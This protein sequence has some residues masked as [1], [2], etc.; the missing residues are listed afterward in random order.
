M[1]RNVSKILAIVMALALAMSFAA[2]SAFAIE[3]TT[4]N[5]FQKYLVVDGD[6]E[7]L[8]D[9]TS[10]FSV[11]AGTAVPG[12]ATTVEIV[13]GPMNP[14]PTIT[15]AAFTSASA[16]QNGLPTD[17]DHNNPTAGSKYAS[18]DVTVNFSEVVFP[19]PGIYRYVITENA[20][21][22]KGVT[23]DPNATRYLDVVVVKDN[24]DRDG[25]GNV[26]ELRVDT[27]V[28]RTQPESIDRNGDYVVGDPN[29]PGA[30]T[31]SYTNTYNTVDLEFSK[32]I[33]GN[34]G[35][36][37]KQFK[38]TLQIQGA[39]P[40]V[41]AVEVSRADVVQD[42]SVTANAGTY[43]ITADANGDCTAYFYLADG[44]TVKVL[45]LPVGYTYTL[46]EDPEDYTSSPTLA[47]YTDA[48]S[49]SGVNADKKTGYT[50]TR[51]GIIPTGVIITVAPF[52]IG[53]LVFGAII[54]YVSA[55]RRRAMY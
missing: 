36:K 7:V 49:G 40:G 15:A 10:T 55:R 39:N 18:Q 19:A 53:L 45:D 11:A 17:Q 3:G 32:A 37:N 48:T 5:T 52:V 1:K 46:T 28:M 14:A 54:L 13:P 31:S 29:N 30:K 8:P 25:D 6:N 22:A 38:F 50:N 12:T 2:V 21:T 9:V 34:Q 35:D 44:D 4:S 41:Y 51:E 20:P 23:N 42:N 24:Q 27:Y 43:T 33:A 47:S 26:E 16:L